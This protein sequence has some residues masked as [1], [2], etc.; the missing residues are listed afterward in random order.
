VFRS[1][2]T[3]ILTALTAICLATALLIVP[4]ALWVISDIIERAGE[5]ELRSHLG[6]IRARIEQQSAAATALA[7]FAAT[8]PPARAALR[9]GDRAA[10]AA[11]TVATFQAL[12]ER[13][14]VDQ[15]RYHL[16]PATSFLR[17]HQ[18]AKFGDDLSGFRATVVATNRD[19]KGIGGLEG[20]VAGLGIRGVVPVESDGRHVGSVEFGLT[21]R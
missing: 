19:R 18:P 7:T 9:D 13:G 6:D 8:L 2:T 21:V 1:L 10:L 16:P 5:R 20:G 15:F 11:L 14:G 17:V 4:G 3:R 12:R